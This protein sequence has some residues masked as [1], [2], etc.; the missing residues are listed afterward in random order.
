VNTRSRKL[1]VREYVSTAE[2]V[3]GC[4]VTSEGHHRNPAD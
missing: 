3:G 1:T 2:G 4:P